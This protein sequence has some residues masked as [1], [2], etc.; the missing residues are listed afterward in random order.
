MLRNVYLPFYQSFFINER[1]IFVA[2]VS[3]M[4]NETVVIWPLEEKPTL[5]LVM[6]AF[7]T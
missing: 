3:H 6:R 5:A 1:K 4:V 2:S 7:S